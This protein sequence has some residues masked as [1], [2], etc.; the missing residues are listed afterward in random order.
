MILI[1]PNLTIK[2]HLI[3][4]IFRFNHSPYTPSTF[5]LS[6]NDAQN[7]RYTQVKDLNLQEN[8]VDTT[9]ISGTHTLP[10]T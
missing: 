6:K 9:G 8:I 4:A 3:L 1:K 10:N 7:G 2:I 5:A